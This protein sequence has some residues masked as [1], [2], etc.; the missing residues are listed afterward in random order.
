MLFAVAASNPK[1]SAMKHG[2]AAESL[3]RPRPI[4]ADKHSAACGNPPAGRHRAETFPRKPA[5]NAPPT[6]APRVANAC[7]PASLPA[8]LFGAIGERSA[9]LGQFFSHLVNRRSHIK[10]QIGGDL[11]VAAATAVQFVS[12]F[13]NQRGQLLLDEVVHVLSFVVSRKSGEAA[14]ISPICCSP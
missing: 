2:Q 14:A 11:L 8:G 4:P 1:F 13:A 5:T 9:D 10:P 3:P 12:N 6:P 7:R